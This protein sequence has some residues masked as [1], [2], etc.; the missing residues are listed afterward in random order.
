MRTMRI[1]AVFALAFVGCGML[2][3]G[4][5]VKS[6]LQPG[7]KIPGPFHPLNVNGAQAGKKHC[8]VCENGTNPVAMVFARECNEPLAKLIAELDAAAEKNKEARLGTFV[9]FLG[10]ED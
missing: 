7:E 6:S 3:A 10:E 1:V 2:L 4:D 8:L 9:V 5:A